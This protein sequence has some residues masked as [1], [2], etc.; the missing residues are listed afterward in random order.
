M[1]HTL[2]I[3]EIFQRFPCL[4]FKK[5]G[6]QM[7]GTNRCSKLGVISIPYNIIYEIIIHIYEDNSVD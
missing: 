1:T 6:I 7:I 3:K 5:K 4:Y 2:S